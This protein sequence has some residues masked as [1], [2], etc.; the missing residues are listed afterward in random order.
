[1]NSEKTTTQAE[2]VGHRENPKMRLMI[3]GE[4]FDSNKN[5]EIT[6]YS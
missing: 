5:F 4:G 1:M 2:V 6:V 3:R